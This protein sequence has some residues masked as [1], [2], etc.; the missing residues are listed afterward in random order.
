L[1]IFDTNFLLGSGKACT[2]TLK[3]SVAIVSL[4]VCG[5]I[6]PVQLH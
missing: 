3:L 1:D 4:K 6:S 2:L 5:R